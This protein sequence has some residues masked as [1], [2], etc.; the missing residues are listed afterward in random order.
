[1]FY[2]PLAI[3]SIGVV[4]YG[5]YP[6]PPC[7]KIMYILK[8]YGVKYTSVTSKKKGS[9]YNKIPVLVIGDKQ[10]NDSQIIA[11]ILANVL[12]V[13]Y[14][15]SELKMENLSTSGLMIALELAVA[16][17]TAELQKCGCA[18][19]GCMGCSL[20]TIA[21]CIPCCGLG[22]PMRKKNPDLKSS[23]AYGKDY[24][25]LLSSKTFFHGDTAGI[26][27]CSIFGLLS[28]FRKA[29][30]QAYTDFVGADSRLLDW[31]GRM[32]SLESNLPLV[33]AIQTQPAASTM[34]AN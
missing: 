29:K 20:W 13:P 17:D 1:M 15:E 11:T 10:I 6:S 30:N 12:D 16:E 7:C 14:S 8:H 22:A 34:H 21:C 18:M 26:I 5:Q 2:L 32:D 23:S 28:P 33:S 4:L 25:E 19:G 3:S 24:A 31:V 27:D 9:K